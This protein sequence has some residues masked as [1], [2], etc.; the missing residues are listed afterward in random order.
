MSI[1][2]KIEYARL[3]AVGARIFEQDDQEAVKWDK[4]IEELQKELEADNG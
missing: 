3:R 4:A 2:D 1:K